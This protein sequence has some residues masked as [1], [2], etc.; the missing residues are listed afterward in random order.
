MV[1]LTILP[2]VEPEKYNSFI[3]AFLYYHCTILPQSSV[4]EVMSSFGRQEA[5]ET[6]ARTK[7]VAKLCILIAALIELQCSTDTENADLCLL[8]TIPMTDL[9]ENTCPST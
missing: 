1:I 6:R 4:I 3:P 9:A 5:A 2:P 7:N 8:Y